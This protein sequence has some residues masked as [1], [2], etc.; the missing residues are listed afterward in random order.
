MRKTY[1]LNVYASES[2]VWSLVI[3]HCTCTHRC[4]NCSV[5]ANVYFIESN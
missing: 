1:T 2:W 5:L 4:T 3:Y